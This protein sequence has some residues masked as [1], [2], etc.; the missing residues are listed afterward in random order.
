MRRL[1]AAIMMAVILC[2]SIT[3]SILR[4]YTHEPG[5][6][7]EIAGDSLY[8]VDS[9][10]VY[11]PMN[12]SDLFV[13][14]LG[15]K[16]YF[17]NPDMR[18]QLEYFDLSH[19]DIISKKIPAKLFCY[20]LI[21][22]YTSYLIKFIFPNDIKE[23]GD[24]AFFLHANLHYTLPDSLTKLGVASFLTS[25]A[26]SDG[27]I[28]D[29]VTVIPDSCF[30]RSF[31]WYKPLHL[32]AGL[33]KVCKH[34]FEYCSSILNIELP[35]SLETIESHAFNGCDPDTTIIPDNPNL[36]IGS[37]GFWYSDRYKGPIFSLSTVPPV[38]SDDGFSYVQDRYCYVPKGTID[39]YSS[40]P[41]WRNIKHFREILPES[42]IESVTTDSG[43]CI[44]TT[45]GGLTAEGYEHVKVYT[46]NGRLVLS[47]S[48]ADLCTHTLT[49][50]IYLIVADEEA[51]KVKI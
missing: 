22:P 11:G 44:R 20:G 37:R 8:L 39:I 13:M 18:G 29:G 21:N 34:A 43:K 36:T 49:P 9:L 50:G 26:P 2:V 4:V 35:P 51:F 33:K 15:L 23:I 32:P 5:T 6:F 1:I 45:T 25:V 41:G 28:P 48:G 7:K 19:A 40:A 10:E 30:A 14:R 16:A 42:E 38:C 47:T 3:A 24:S 27:I 12:D 46:T 31:Y 17:P